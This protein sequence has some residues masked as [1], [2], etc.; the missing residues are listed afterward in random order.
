MPQHPLVLEITLVLTIKLIVILA[1]ALFVFS[2]RQRPR[3]DAASMQ[4]HL[5]GAATEKQ[6]RSIS[7]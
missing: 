7:P 3:I 2:P 4:E 1:A 5:I 6:P